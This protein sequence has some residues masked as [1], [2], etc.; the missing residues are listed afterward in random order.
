MNLGYVVAIA[1]AVGMGCASRHEEVKEGLSI[2]SNDGTRVTG[3]YLSAG[4]RILFESWPGS[5]RLRSATG[6]EL[7]AVDG[8]VMRH[9]GEP[10]I[11]SGSAYDQPQS[12]KWLESEEARVVATLWRD[13]HDTPLATTLD[14][15]YRYGLHLDE[16]IGL[17]ARELG[18]ERDHCTG[19][20]YGKCGPGCFSVGTNSY[21]ERHDCCCRHYGSGA[22][23]T[24]CFAN[25][26]CPHPG[27]C[28]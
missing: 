4:T 26:K 21:C 27:G 2:E 25:P 5:L 23:Y 8:D 6:E 18:G 1:A 7:V 17:K 10:L 3:S 16:V 22:C 9:Y 14:P 12:R 19:N 13:L 11:M 24:W 28:G 15:L 20:C